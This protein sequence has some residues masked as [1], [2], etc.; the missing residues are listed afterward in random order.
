MEGFKRFI[1]WEFRRGSWQYDVVVIGMLAFVFLTP[2]SWFKDQPRESQ[3]EI[4]SS[5]PGIFL[6]EPRLLRDIP[7]TD[8]T[9][10]TSE[11]LKAK[12]GKPT[13]VTRVEPVLDAEEQLIGFRAFT[14]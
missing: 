14:R 4:L 3:I 12:Y 11:L 5:N 2:R 1:F 6:L 8:R 13:S 7:E 9:A 10:K